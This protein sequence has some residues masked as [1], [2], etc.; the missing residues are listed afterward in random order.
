[1]EVCEGGDL[2]QHLKKHGSLP[3]KE[4]KAITVQVL[5]VLKYLS[6]SAPRRVIHYDLKPPNIL[7][8]ALGQARVTDFGLSKEVN[9]GETMGQDLTSRGAGTYW[10]LPPECFDTRPVISSKVDVWSLGCIVFQMVYGR[11][12][13][14]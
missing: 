4:A 7:F 3:E 14:G 12:P 5:D 10:Y 11:R 2:D 8:D 1:M 9:P 6:Q 13:F